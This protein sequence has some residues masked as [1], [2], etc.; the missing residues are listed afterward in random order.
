MEIDPQHLKFSTIANLNIVVRRKLLEKRY[1]IRVAVPIHGKTEIGHVTQ[2]IIGEKV[3]RQFLVLES[4][5]LLVV[6]QK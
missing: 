1:E 3:S 4:I 6:H 2:A 5:D